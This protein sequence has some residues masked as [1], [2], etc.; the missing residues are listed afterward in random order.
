MAMATALGLGVATVLNPG[1]G[2]AITMVYGAFVIVL[3]VFFGLTLI[4]GRVLIVSDAGLRGARWAW[5]MDIP[6][7]SVRTFETTSLSGQR[8]RGSLVTV[9][10]VN[11][12][13]FFLPCTG[14]TPE[15]ATMITNELLAA[16]REHGK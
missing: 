6:W 9:C 2:G 7:S 5:R 15:S 13:H 16:Q 8:M 12:R 11:G 10:L 4:R 14:G 1:Q 3:G